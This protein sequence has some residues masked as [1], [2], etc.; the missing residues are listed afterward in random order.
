MSRISSQSKGGQQKL[1]ACMAIPVQVLKPFLFSVFLKQSSHEPA[2]S[3]ISTARASEISRAALSTS[4]E[5]GGR[6]INLPRD[7]LALSTLP[8]RRR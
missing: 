4:V 8:L 7:T 2:P 6:V 3:L 5:L 1:T